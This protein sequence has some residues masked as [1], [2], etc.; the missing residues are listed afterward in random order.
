MERTR[1][2]KSLSSAGC[3]KLPYRVLNRQSLVQV[4][5]ATLQIFASRAKHFWPWP[6]SKE[7]KGR[8]PAG[9]ATTLGEKKTSQHALAVNLKSPLYPKPVWFSRSKSP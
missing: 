2:G 5:F 4:L 6:K 7:A 9:H 3:R 1:P 8:G